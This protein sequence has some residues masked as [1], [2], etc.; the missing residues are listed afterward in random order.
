MLYKKLLERKTIN[1]GISHELDIWNDADDNQQKTIENFFSEFIFTYGTFHE[2]LG[3][4][5]AHGDNHELEI[6]II[7]ENIL[8]EGKTYLE[9]EWMENDQ[10]EDDEDNFISFKWIFDKKGKLILIE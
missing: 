2:L 1:V 6:S 9:A 8:M 10:D 7:D 4:S 5:N 3:K